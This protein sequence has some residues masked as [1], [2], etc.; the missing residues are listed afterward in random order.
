MFWISGLWVPTRQ[1]PRHAND[2]LDGY[3]HKRNLKSWLDI[4]N[5]CGDCHHDQRTR[6]RGERPHGGGCIIWRDGREDGRKG[7]G[8]RWW[9]AW[10]RGIWC[11]FGVRR[12]STTFRI[13]F[14]FFTFFIVWNSS[15]KGK[16]NKCDPE[17]IRMAFEENVL[18][19]NIVMENTTKVAITSHGSGINH[20]FG[21]FP[22]T[23]ARTMFFHILKER[24]NQVGYA[25]CSELGIGFITASD[26][27]PIL[28][29]WSARGSRQPPGWSLA[30]T[31]PLAL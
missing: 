18:R 16:I 20:T 15:G 5:D 14:S 12:R 23:S 8:H 19:T 28:L 6:G 17:L 30:S 10:S 21:G 1:R 22:V 31:L 29:G 27:R 4:K 9:S 11:R 3:L 7:L 26:A 2:Y 24:H 13:A 25:P